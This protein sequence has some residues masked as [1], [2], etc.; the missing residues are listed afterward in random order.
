MHCARWMA[1]VIYSLKLWL[2]RAQFKLTKKK[3]DGLLKICLFVV[4]IYVK[5]WF[6]ATSAIL[7]SRN[8]PLLLKEIDLYKAKVEVISK[9][10]LKKMLGHLW[11]LSEVLIASSFFDKQVPLDTKRKM[12]VRL[13]TPGEDHPLKRELEDFV[14][15]NTLRFFTT[16]GVRSDFFEKD[17]EERENDEV[18]Q[19]I[20]AT[21]AHMR[22]F[23]DIAERGVALM[24]EYNKLNTNNEEQKQFLLLAVKE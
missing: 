2:F 14:T 12:V 4:R 20:K 16:T 3:C 8:D 17:V 18:Y 11:Y 9:V 24:D 15:S 23:N 22:V 21:V 19:S 5:F 1:Q 10:G 13:G 6:Q 7:S